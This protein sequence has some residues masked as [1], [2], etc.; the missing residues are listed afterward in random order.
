MVVSHLVKEG[1]PA[2]AVSPFGIWST[3]TGEVVTHNA[4]DIRKMIEDGLVPV[5][6]GD[7]VLYVWYLSTSV[8]CADI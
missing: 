3:K 4:K 8:I 7:V 5:L 1:V 6:H 2:V